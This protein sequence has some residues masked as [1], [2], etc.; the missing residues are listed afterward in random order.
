MAHAPHT[1][2]ARKNTMERAI[3]AVDELAGFIVAVALVKP[4]KKL[5]EVDVKSVHKKLKQKSFAAAVKREEIELGAKELGF[6]LD[7]H[8]NHVL[9]AMKEITEELGL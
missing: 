8:I 6:S 9:S 1:G 5:A 7:E 2:T 4:N 3:F